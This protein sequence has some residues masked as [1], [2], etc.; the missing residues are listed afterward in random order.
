MDN[1]E[2]LNNW[3]KK[4]KLTLGAKIIK[5]YV[6]QLGGYVDQVQLVI[7]EIGQDKKNKT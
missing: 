5:K 3:L 6:P 1:Q 7:Q 4:N 2:K